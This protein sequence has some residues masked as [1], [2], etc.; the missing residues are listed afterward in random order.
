MFNIKFCVL[1]VVGTFLGFSTPVLGE[2]CEINITSTQFEPYDM[3]G[4]SLFTMPEY[5][6]TDIMY[7]IELSLFNNNCIDI[8][9]TVNITVS[10]CGDSCKIY[11][12]YGRT[13]QN[14]SYSQFSLPEN[15]FLSYITIN[16]HRKS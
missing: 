13:L 5:L 16:I 6:S 4:M 15:P 10:I 14:T 1:L 12:F 3:G 8:N 7:R 2:S 9:N 11:E